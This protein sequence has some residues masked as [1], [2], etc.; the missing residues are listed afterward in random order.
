MK[1]TFF[2]PANYVILA[3]FGMD[4]PPSVWYN[5]SNQK[6]ISKFARSA[7]VPNGWLVM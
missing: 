5:Q 3:D 6:E 7:Y 2:S 1:I 4:N